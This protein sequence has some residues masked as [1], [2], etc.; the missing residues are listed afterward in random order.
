METITVKI[1]L[2]EQEISNTVEMKVL[3]TIL[4]D[5]LLFLENTYFLQIS[6][7]QDRQVCGQVE[8]SVRW[9]KSSV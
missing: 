4:S 7:L 8:L 2:K 9:I 5:T 1:K 3:I 6:R